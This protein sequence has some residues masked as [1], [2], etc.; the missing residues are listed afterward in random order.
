MAFYGSTFLPQNPQKYNKIEEMEPW[1]YIPVK[2][3]NDDPST[4]LKSFIYTHKTGGKDQDIYR[5]ELMSSNGNYEV[6]SIFYIILS[7][8]TAPTFFCFH[9]LG[10]KVCA[11]LRQFEIGSGPLLEHDCQ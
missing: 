2:G 5:D 8:E 11:R 1:R 10:I 6:L 9:R 3:S 7:F 4:R